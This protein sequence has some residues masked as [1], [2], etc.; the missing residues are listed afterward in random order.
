MH[1]FLETA[2]HL[3]TDL[4]GFLDGFIAVTPVRVADT[5]VDTRTF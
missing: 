4:P 5:R 1:D 2:K 3:F